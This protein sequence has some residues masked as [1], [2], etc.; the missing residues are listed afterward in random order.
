M[1]AQ[2][3]GEKQFKAWR[4]GYTV[5]PP[6]VSSFSLDYPG[7]DR[8]YK[9]I[10]DLRYSI[11]ESIMRS[12]DSGKLELHRKLPKTESLKDCMSRVI[13]YFCDEI[14][15]RVEEGKRVLISSSENAIRGL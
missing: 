12:F 2:Q 4:R 15:P 7:N 13:P 1:I 14:Q 10:Y 3:Y 11:S 9:Y 8:R 6:K 5:R